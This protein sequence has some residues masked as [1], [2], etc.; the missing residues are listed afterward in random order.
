MSIA[1]LASPYAPGTED[2][3]SAHDLHMTH[4]ANTRSS[5]DTRLICLRAMARWLEPSSLL[6]ATSAPSG[7]SGGAQWTFASV[8]SP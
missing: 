6:D 8:G 7:R 2:L 1:P 5:I 4:R 3:L